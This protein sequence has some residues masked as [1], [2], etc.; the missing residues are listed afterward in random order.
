VAA[1]EEKEGVLAVLARPGALTPAGIAALAD[2]VKVD[3]EVV[4]P[5]PV[6]MAP[7]KDGD[8]RA[9]A[10]S[11]AATAG[12]WAV[13]EEGP[14][15]RAFASRWLLAPEALVRAAPG[16]TPDVEA[17]RYALPKA[18]SGPSGMKIAPS[19]AAVPG[20]LAVFPALAEETITVVGRTSAAPWEAVRKALEAV[21]PGAAE[22][23]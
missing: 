21:V 19:A 18:P 11:L 3:L 23:R 5:V 9:A 8:P 1:V 16:W 14:G 7:P 6:A 17:R 12:V 2:R 13:G 20:V 4:E 22:K 10:G 15:L